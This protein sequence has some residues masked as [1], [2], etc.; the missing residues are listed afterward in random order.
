MIRGKYGL[1]P[2]LLAAGLLLTGGV[3]AQTAGT[4]QVFFERT[5]SANAGQ[6]IFENVLTGVR[7]T[8]D[9][10][11]TGFATAGD[12]VLY[13]DRETGLVMRATPDEQPEAHPFMQMRPGDT[14]IDW[15]ASEDGT[16]I[17]WTHTSGPSN[18]LVTETWASRSDGANRGLIFRDGPRDGIRAYP[19]TFS[20]DNKRVYMDYQPDAIG[21]IAPYRQFAALF[22]LDIAT[23]AA[24]SLPGEAGCFCGADIFDDQLVRLVLGSGGFDVRTVHLRTEVSHLISAPQPESFTLGGDVLVSPTAQQAVYVLGR[25][26]ESGGRETQFVLVDIP[27]EQ[28]R[29][30][31]DVFLEPLRPVAWTSDGNGVL[32]VNVNT[33]GTWLLDAKDGT[34]SQVAQA[35]YVGVLD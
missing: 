29:P 17:A 27:A 33:Q 9:A 30:L 20:A 11:G 6:L 18:A 4:I 7:D 15:A 25:R 32:L 26:T 14:R 8:A 22:A 3:L 12:A 10:A 35:D 31:G 16:W 13:F 28:A 23:G 1:M 24:T 5:Q 19:L 21:L 34:L 2:L